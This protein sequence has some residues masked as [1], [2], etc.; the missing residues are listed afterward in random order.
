MLATNVSG[1]RRKPVASPKSPLQ[2]MLATDVKG[3]RR[4]TVASSFLPVY[5]KFLAHLRIT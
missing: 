2:P 5:Y 3:P 1:P 4:K